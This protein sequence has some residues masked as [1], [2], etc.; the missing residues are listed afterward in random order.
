MSDLLFTQ[1]G[2]WTVF[3]LGFIL[4]LMVWFVFKVMK[5]SKQNPDSKK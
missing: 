3:T 2:F 5:L 4:V 1:M